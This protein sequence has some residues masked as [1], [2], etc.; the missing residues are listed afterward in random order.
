MLQG[1]YQ[2]FTELAILSIFNK[3]KMLLFIKTKSFAYMQVIHICYCHSQHPPN[4]P[5]LKYLNEINIY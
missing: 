5:H 2:L 1:L 4:Y 3:V